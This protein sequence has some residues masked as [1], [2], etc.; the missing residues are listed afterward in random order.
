MPNYSY[1][2]KNK[3]YIKTDTLHSKDLKKHFKGK[4]EFS[5]NEIA[6]FY[7]SFDPNIKRTT[8]NWRIYKLVELGVIQRVGRGVFTLGE[9]KIFQP[10]ISADL[11]KKYND[12]KSN[13]PFIELCIW[14]TAII[15]EFS[16]HQSNRRL[17]IIETEKDANESIF[18]FLKER[19]RNVFFNPNREILEQYV[20]DI[21]NAIIVKPLL[22][23]S[24]LQEVK[25]VN[26][27]SIEKM[28]VDIYCD[29]DIFEAFQGNEKKI[30][31]SVAFEKYTINSNKLL[32]YASRRGR[33]EEIEKLILQ[34]TGNNTK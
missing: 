32:R 19:Y 1:V 26:T 29:T 3:N 28:L 18:Y 13:F 30:I 17:V 15:N 4:V 16:H 10:D 24:P 2:C 27:I 12:I 7:H 20:F 14:N 22:S 6:K 34:I 8:I 25:K 21:P 11:I 33:K 31:Y 23:E 9:T 5:N